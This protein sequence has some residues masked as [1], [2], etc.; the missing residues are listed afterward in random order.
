MNHRFHDPMCPDHEGPTALSC[1]LLSW[2]AAIDEPDIDLDEMFDALIEALTTAVPT[3]VAVKMTI[4][5]GGRPVT[6][7]S[8]SPSGAS[9]GST[10]SFPLP[11]AQAGSCV[12]ILAA[13]APGAF[14][15]LAHEAVTELGVAAD[16]RHD[17]HLSA[18]DEPDDPGLDER[19]VIDVAVGVLLDDGCLTAESAL[20]QLA[21]RA[22]RCGQ[23]LLDAANATIAAAA[24]GSEDEHMIEFPRRPPIDGTDAGPTAAPT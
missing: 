22:T 20:E 13:S 24:A 19:S 1:A 6:I 17:A 7:V 18:F 15:G 14:A 16:I 2:T 9:I 3:L 12:L 23:S 10:L 5:V 11:M 4:D 21:E 8:P